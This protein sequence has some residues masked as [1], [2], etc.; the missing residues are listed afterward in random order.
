VVVVPVAGVQSSVGSKDIVLQ[1][2]DPDPT[3]V[4]RNIVTLDKETKSLLNITSGDIVQIEGGKKTGAI[5]WPAR[6]EDEG[7]KIIRMDSF[8]RHNAGVGLNEKVKVQKVVPL[9]AKK[10]ILAPIEEVRIIASG[11]DRILKKSFLGRPLNVGDNVWISVFG[12][13]FI[14]RV[15]DTSPRGIVKV[16][17]NTQFSLKEKPVK[18][19]L[20]NVPKVA[21]E[22]IGGLG[23]QVKKVRE[24]VELP[25]KHPEL[26]QKLGIIPPKGILLFGPPGTGKTLLAKAV[27]NEAQVHFISVSAPEIMGKFVGEAEERVR[28]LFKDAQENAPSIIFIDEIDAIAPKRDEV[29]GEV[30]RRVV[31]QILSMMDG[32]E[33]RGEVIVMAATNRINSIDEALRRPGRFD[34]EVEFTVPDKKAREQ[35]LGIH[36]RGMPLETEGKERVDLAFFASITHGFV[37]ADLQALTKEAAMKALRRYL[38]QIDLEEETIPPEVLEKLKINQQDFVDGLKDVQPSALREVAVEVPNVRWEQIG[39]LDFVKEEL[40]QAIEWP[41]KNPRAFA[42]MGIRPPK[43]VL[44]FGPP[45]TGKT[46]LAKAIATESEANFISVKGPELLSVW[47]GDSEKGVRKIFKK[48]RQ[49]SPCIVFFDELDAI[50]PKRGTELGNNVTERM[51]NQLLTELDGVEVLTDVVFIAATNRPDLIDPAL[52]RP[53]RIDKLIMVPA[54][55]EKAREAILKV[56]VKNVRLDKGVDLKVLAQRTKGFSGADLEGLVREAALLVLQENKMKP[57]SITMKHFEKIL[58][59]LSPTID[60]LSEK[61]YAEFKENALDFRPSYVR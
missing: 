52:L 35:I 26:F 9:E 25:M 53:G 4:G 45:G 57:A 23:E 56:H 30:E 18:D 32:L 36:T 8:I 20:S 31:A 17:D 55:D 24:M 14:Y 6:T 13:G 28:N 3:H 54:P 29:I 27:A 15:V 43:G 33:G 48:A 39:A 34:R 59:K 1:V 11:Y 51:V 22:D 37:G 44:L 2:L 60:E 16:T 19:S 49:V 7:K 58:D 61:A 38:P 47:V 12:S 21:Y 42:E 50:A 5:V 46:L 41:I 10:V 40:K